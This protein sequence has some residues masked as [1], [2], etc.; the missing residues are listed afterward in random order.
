MLGSGFMAYSGDI[1]LPYIWIWWISAAM[2]ASINWGWR[3][4]SWI[5]EFQ[6]QIFCRGILQNVNV[7]FYAFNNS[8]G[9]SNEWYYSDLSHWL[10]RQLPLSCCYMADF[11]HYRSSMDLT[12]CKMQNFLYVFLQCWTNTLGSFLSHFPTI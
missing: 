6:I 11:W 9:L 4:F 8:L 7:T 2:A 3:L 1:S 10:Y 5:M 12:F